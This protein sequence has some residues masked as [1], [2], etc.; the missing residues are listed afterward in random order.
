[1]SGSPDVTAGR[2]PAGEPEAAL[3]DLQ[4][5]FVQAILRQDATGLAERIV[6]GGIGPE[7]RLAIYRTTARENFALALEAAFPLVHASLGHEEFRRMAWAYQRACPSPAGNLFHVGER[8]PGF[9]GERLAG[10][11]DEYLVD[12]ARLEW[13]VQ[14]S[15][16][17]VD[18]TSSLDLAALAAVPAERQ[19]SIRFRLHPSVR[20]LQS[21]YAVFDQ[22]EVFQAGRP[23]APAARAPEALL[24]QRQSAGIQVRRIGAVDCLWLEALQEGAGLGEAAARLPAD[25]GVDLGALLVAWVG[26]GVVT[27][28]GL[29]E[30]PDGRDRP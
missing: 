4:R 8:L 23:V 13:A 21:R 19:A 17:A 2:G 5:R 14:E 26:C 30:P 10:T 29:D 22:W 28:F 15:L 1:M 6:P 16:V 25:A 12:T 9:L 20:L 18:P 11:A 24:V 3:G 27:G 7:R